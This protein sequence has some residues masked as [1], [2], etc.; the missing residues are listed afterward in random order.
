MATSPVENLPVPAPV[1]TAA[2]EERK[3]KAL[4]DQ[5]VGAAKNALAV[6]RL[7]TAMAGISDAG[8]P[9]KDRFERVLRACVEGRVA[10]D[11]EGFLT[12]ARELCDGIDREFPEV[13]P[14]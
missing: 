10:T 12:F 3:T 4:E 6:E 5:A 2:L 8:G 13:T 14:T 1:T 7:A 9:K 11:V